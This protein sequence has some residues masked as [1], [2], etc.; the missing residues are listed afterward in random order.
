MSAYT[1]VNY[2]Y[3]SRMYVYDLNASP[4][5]QRETFESLMMRAMED[6]PTE[7]Q[8]MGKTYPT[9]VDSDYERHLW[10]QDPYNVSKG[11]K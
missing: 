1:A 7:Y 11:M 3:Q 4:Y 8:Y 10:D 2:H 6:Q 5:G 9:W